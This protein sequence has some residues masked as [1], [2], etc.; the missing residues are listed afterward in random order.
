MYKLI[1]TSRK[2]LFCTVRD[3]ARAKVHSNVSVLRCSRN[4]GTFFHAITITICEGVGIILVWKRSIFEIWIIVIIISIIIHVNLIWSLANIRSANAHASSGP[5]AQLQL[6]MKLTI[7][8]STIIERYKV[9][10]AIYSLSVKFRWWIQQTDCF[11]NTALW[12]HNMATQAHRSLTFSSLAD[13][14]ELRSLIV[15]SDAGVHELPWCQA[16][17]GFRGRN[18]EHKWQWHVSCATVFIRTIGKKFS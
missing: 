12:T 8:L 3:T 13:E 1:S 9:M 15:R 16:D 10:L 18:W 4:R 14:F 5:H 7:I 6:L 2:C 17:L 11:I